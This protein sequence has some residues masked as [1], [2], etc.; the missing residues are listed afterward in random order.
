MINSQPLSY[1]SSDDLE[2][3]VTIS[4]QIFG[5]RILNLPDNLDHICNFND[6]D[7]TLSSDQA[8]ARVKHLNDVLS[9]FWKRWGMEWLSNLREVHANTAKKR[10]RGDHSQVSV[11]QVII[12][13]D[14]HLPCGLW[15]LEICQGTHDRE[16]WQDKSSH[17]LN[18]LA[19][20]S[21]H[22]IKQAHITTISTR[23]SLHARSQ[24]AHR[25]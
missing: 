9:H 21:T 12:V 25:S 3:P 24:W 2:K 1:F 23:T 22:H 19:K 5:H 11:G 20:S 6:D 10:H 16:G 15:K 17:C 13:K 7:F 8:T 18:S 4:H 14:D